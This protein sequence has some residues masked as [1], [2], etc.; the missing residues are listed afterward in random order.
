MT[1]VIGCMKWNCWAVAAA[2]TRMLRLV[3]ASHSP[4]A[5]D[6]DDVGLLS[7]ISVLAVRTIWLAMSSGFESSPCALVHCRCYPSPQVYDDMDLDLASLKLLAKG[8]HGGHNG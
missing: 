4:S 1:V 2:A 8:G 7:V 3:N 6:I 5:H